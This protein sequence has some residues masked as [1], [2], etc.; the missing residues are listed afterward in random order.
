VFR[1]GMA[2]ALILSVEAV[3]ADGT[4]VGT[5]SKMLK[6]NTGY[7]LKQLFIGSEG[8]LGIIT[9]LVLRLH[10][11]PRAVCTGLCAVNGYD[12]VLKLLARA[13][14][15]LGPTLSAFELMMPKVYELSSSWPGRR[16][17]LPLGAGGYVLIETMG[18]HQDDDQAHFEAMMAGAIEDG[19]V[20]DAVVCQS[21]KDTENL[22]AIRDHAG[23]ARHVLG[24]LVNFDISV[25]TSR[26]GVFLDEVGGRLKQRWPG[27]IPTCFGHV[28][29]GNIHFAV[30][31]DRDPLPTAEVEELVYATVAEFG[32]AISAE[33]G[34]GV[35]KKHA[36]HYSRTEDEIV[37]MRRLKATLDPN[38][39]LNPGKV[40]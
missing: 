28:A 17:P 30:I 3:L 22:W 21:G 14:D 9:R 40:L 33:H 10:P 34:L 20:S 4:V 32:G 18:A 19:V 8:T 23:D 2:R 12:D 16:R 25:P 38:G 36:L 15:E 24:P 1:F 37:L 27:A 5:L 35:H 13:R 39:I 29:D 7:D 11:K 26:I 31:I 6:N